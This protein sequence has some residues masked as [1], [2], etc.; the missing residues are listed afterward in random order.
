M[1]HN[2]VHFQTNSALQSVNTRNRRDVRRPGATLFCFQKSVYCSGIKIFCSL[3]CSLK[4]L[5]NRTV[6]FEAALKVI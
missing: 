1:V 3:P 5:I 6:Q 2:Q 4:S